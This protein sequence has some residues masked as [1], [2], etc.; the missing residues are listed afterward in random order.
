MNVNTYEA[1]MQQAKD[2]DLS[3]CI[4]HVKGENI[5]HYEKVPDASA[6]IMPINSCTKSVLSALVCIAMDQGLVPEPKT[7]ASTFFPQLLQAADERKR[8]ITLEH[9]LTLTPGFE[10]NEFGGL[11]SFPKMSRTSNWI[12]YTLNQP[13]ADEPG[14]KMVYNSG[15]S[16]MLAELL[17]QSIDQPIEAYAERYL[18]G[19]LGI[20][21]YEWKQ[22]PQGI[23]TGGFGLFLTAR[24][25]LKFGQ[26]YLNK[27]VWDGNMLISEK[28]IIQSTLPTIAASPPERGYY[29]W[30]WWVD[31]VSV[32]NCNPSLGVTELNY[33][34]ARGF[35][36][37]FIFIIP[38]KEAVVVTTRTPRK[39]GLFP[40][41]LFRNHIAEL[42]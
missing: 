19:P 24:D 31:N 10:W 22:D 28:R 41:D 35:G 11:N 2:Y 39:K 14:T 26:L 8:A 16:Q 6:H 9:I 20:Q 37:Q 40:H 42:L 38:S 3:S 7:A 32:P 34:Y 23:A 13:I 17:A 1:T 29:G 5:F 25:L 27:G 30:H 4:I 33:Y 36:G 15:V 18:F 21:Q 12:E